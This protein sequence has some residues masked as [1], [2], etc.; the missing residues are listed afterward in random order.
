MSRVAL[1]TAGY[2]LLSAAVTLAVAGVGLGNFVILA[3]AAFLLFLLF[4]G[5][6][7][8]S[9]QPRVT[10]TLRSTRLRRGEEGEVDVE[11]E[12]PA[13]LAFV[14]VHQP[15][16]P[17][18][19]LE[20]GSNVR[21]LACR[22]LAA[23]RVAFRVRFRAT[24]RGTYA[25]PPV[26]WEAVGLLGL[27]EP[28]RGTAAGEV[29][30]DVAP[31]ATR[32]AG[33]ARV[34]AARRALAESGV[35]R[36]G[37]RG[38]DYKEVRDY[39]W[40]DPSKIINWKAT[41]KRVARGGTVRPYVNEYEREGKRT[42]FIFLDASRALDVGTS[43]ETALDDAVDAAQGIAAYYLSQGYRVGACAFNAGRGADGEAGAAPIYPD[44]G[45][46]HAARIRDALA[47][48]D[49]GSGREGLAG[50]AERCQGFLRQGSTLVFVV[51]RVT[52]PADAL[53]AGVRRLRASLAGSITHR[54]PLVVVNVRPY[55][56][57]PGEG[58][59]AQE[60]R[61]L[62]N[63]LDDPPARLVARAG[64]QV[65]SWDPSRDSFA[66]V[67]LRRVRA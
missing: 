25:L 63:L 26:A 52:A 40:G 10:R 36:I 64:A 39:Q 65:I 58:P 47:V 59:R 9:L 43:V 53:L 5:T 67:F 38:T 15:L 28:L 24:R 56:L 12:L 51:T 19:S 57:L 4:A 14:E 46:A 37:P 18:F 45:D 11:V 66:A 62:L 41:A 1:T 34:R 32:L 44:S 55:G 48:V 60:A 33:A 6:A 2:A 13:G 16:P 20:G 49:A 61:V 54:L 21:L 42:V 50:A 31:R 17:E 3:V 27:E 35:T 23:R 22:P 29:T 7:R 8:A 30:V